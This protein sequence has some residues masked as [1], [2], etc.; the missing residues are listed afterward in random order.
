MT[1]YSPTNVRVRFLP[2]YPTLP[3][4]TAL[5]GVGC[6]EDRAKP[7]TLIGGHRQLT[8]LRMCTLSALLCLVVPEHWDTYQEMYARMLILHSVPNSKIE[9]RLSDV[10]FLKVCSPIASGVHDAELTWFYV[11]GAAE[12]SERLRM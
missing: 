10:Q 4:F 1:Q 11:I 6:S 3:S 7:T 8:E 5:S 12:V 2:G 9:L